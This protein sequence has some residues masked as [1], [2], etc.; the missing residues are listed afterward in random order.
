[1]YKSHLVRTLLALVVLLLPAARPAQAQEPSR[2]FPETGHTVRGRFLQH[3]EQHGGLAQQGFPLTEEMI[4]VSDTDGKPYTVQYFERAVFELHPENAPPYDVLLTLLGTFEYG[5]RYGVSGAAGQSANPANPRRFR[6]TGHSIGGAFRTYWEAHGG[7]AQQGF[8][9]SDEFTEVSDLDGKPHTVQYFERAVFE[10][11]PEHAGTPFE[12]LLSQ[13]GTFRQRARLQGFALPAPG[14]GR[15]QYGPLA[16]DTYL[17]WTERNLPPNAG[18]GRDSADIRALDLR[19][20]RLQFVADTPGPNDATSLGG[21]LL[22]WMHGGPGCP[23]ACER[24]LVARDL[25]TGATYQVA[26]GPGQRRNFTGGGRHV[27]WVESYP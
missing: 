18:A 21:S 23:P 6:E 11:H 13:L 4:E 25:A 27:A 3:W 20:N 16:S 5:R 26:G 17:V 22:I 14:P 2:L 9:L 10:H 19:T 8:P 12:V 1:M 7:L 24:N 15:T